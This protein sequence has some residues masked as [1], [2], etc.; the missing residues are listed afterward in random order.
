MRVA[1]AFPNKP[2][3]V[4][5]PSGDRT[6]AESIISSFKMRGHLCVEMTDFRSRW[7]WLNLSALA[8]LPSSLLK[9]VKLYRYFSPHVW[10]TYHSYYKS[11]D[12]FGWWLASPSVPYVII[13]PMR[14]GKRHKRARTKIGA[15]I[16]DM[17]IR[18]SDLLISNNLKDVEALRDFAPSKNIHYIPPGIF[19]E[20]FSRDVEAAARLRFEL[21]IPSG[22]PVLLT[23]SRFREGVKWESLMFLFE[24]LAL[25]SKK[26]KFILLVIGSGPLESRVRAWAH[27]LLKDRAVFLGE[28]KRTELSPYYS[29]ADIFVFPGIGESLGMVYLEAQSC[30]CPVVALR[31][32]G[33][34]QVVSSGRTGIL[35]S[36]HD[37]L[38][39]AKAI[40]FMLQNPVL[41]EKMGKESV[42]FVVKERNAHINNASLVRLIEDLVKKRSVFSW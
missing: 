39:Y 10:I 12:L 23:V 15:L 13:Q 37:I 9:T 17:A 26:R 42:E 21:S 11:P 36:S 2:L 29:L 31:G 8:R 27:R 18:R 33:V 20:L 6:I 24:S 14:A 3:S 19:P 4:K 38:S 28:K 35:V 7:F 22:L 1:F 25:L 16:N 40:D 32:E 5:T 34:E 30:G 41:L